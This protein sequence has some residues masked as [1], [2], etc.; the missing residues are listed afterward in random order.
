MND[1]S[2]AARP[3]IDWDNSPSYLSPQLMGCAHGDRQALRILYAALAE[4]IERRLVR[5][6]R[7]AASADD[8]LQDTFVAVWR[9][10][11]RF[12]PQIGLPI[13]WIWTI[14]R[15][16]A[17]NL[18]ERERR[19]CSLDHIV[20]FDERPDPSPSPYE[21]TLYREESALL[22]QCMSKLTPTAQQCIELAYFQGLSYSEVSLATG[23]PLGTVKTTVRKAFVCLRQCMAHQMSMRPPGYCGD[24][25]D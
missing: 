13:A 24:S 18:L 6:L 1:F 7:N 21:S 9:N 11:H 23:R 10:A 16:K 17:L 14:A 20:A 3:Q 5:L 25:D 19:E 8:V 2:I 12:D 4:R 15:N 22:R